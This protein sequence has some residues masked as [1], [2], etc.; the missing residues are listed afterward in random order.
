MDPKKVKVIVN[1]QESENV[2][3]IKVFIEFANFY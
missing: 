3:D 2:K 1:W